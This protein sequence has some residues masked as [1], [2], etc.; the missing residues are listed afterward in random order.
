[1]D[2]TG[3]KPNQNEGI[4]SIYMNIEQMVYLLLL[5]VYGGNKG[6]QINIIYGWIINNI[7]TSTTST[8][9]LKYQK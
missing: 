4:L 1:M 6:G 7:N 5:L 2:N 8:L 3:N 9:Q